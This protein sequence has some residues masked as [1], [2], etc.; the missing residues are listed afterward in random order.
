M[1]PIRWLSTISDCA[2]FQET[3]DKCRKTLYNGHIEIK[4]ENCMKEKGYKPKRKLTVREQALGTAVCLALYRVL[5]FVPL[6]FVEKGYLKAAVESSTSL[7]FLD[8]LTGGSLGDMSLM[9]LGI[10]PW[11]TASIVLQL[12]G[13]AF[14]KLAEQGRD[15]DGR[16]KRK[17]MTFILSAVLALLEASGLAW[18]LS[19]EGAVAGGAWHMVLP[20][21]CMV[22][23]T[24][25]LSGMAW[26]IDERLFGNGT[27]LILTAGILSSYAGDA[28]AVGER[29]SYGRGILSS[30]VLYILAVFGAAALFGYALFLLSCEKRLPVVYQRQAGKG[31]KAPGNLPLKML[32]GGILPVVFASMMA[33]LPGILAAL[34]HWDAG[35]LAMFDMGQWLNPGKPWASAGLLLYLALIVAFGQF[36]QMLYVNPS[37]VAKQLSDAGG[38]LPGIR[39]GKPTAEHIRRQSRRLVLLG[40]LLLSILAAVPVAVSQ[41]SGMSNLSFFGT[42]VLI[43][44]GA[45]DEAWKEWAAGKQGMTYRKGVF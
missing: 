37:D 12:L 2:K 41:A 18:R 44:A 4:E 20:V 14:P 27:S 40:G 16:R 17:L 24:G 11:I 25:M 45:L 8:A 36:C 33:T 7:S 3:V 38:T 42:G 19:R 6:P 21:L 13:A 35:R 28:A 29:L 32:P 34:F 39:P 15:A 43:V 5:S 10:G 23:G 22:L 1:C 30:A 9:A 31:A 26:L